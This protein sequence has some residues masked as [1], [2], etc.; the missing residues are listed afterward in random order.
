MTLFVL[1]IAPMICAINQNT[2]GVIVI[3]HLMTV[4]AYADD[5]N[6]IVTTDEQSDRIS[7]EITTFMNESHA[8]YNISNQCKMGP[9]LLR[10]HG[11]LNMIGIK[12]CSELE[13]NGGP[14]LQG[15]H[16]Q[17]FIFVSSACRASPK[18]VAENLDFKFVCFVEIMVCGPCVASRK[19]TYQKDKKTAWK[20][21]VE[22]QPS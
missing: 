2:S 16:K 22:R 1:F 10:E 5:I 12:L 13:R 6:Y 18:S 17:D 3:N 21:F 14:N 7:T 19:H 20:L 15:S 9:Q 11:S 8:S 4:F